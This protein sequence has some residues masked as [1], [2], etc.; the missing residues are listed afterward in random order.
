MSTVPTP[1]GTEAQVCRDIALRQQHG[2]AKYGTSVADNRLSLRAW[3][4]HAYQE[5]LDQAIYLRRAIEQ[6]DAA[7]LTG[8]S[9]CADPAGVTT[10]PP[11]PREPY[12]PP[13]PRPAF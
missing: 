5:T 11:A 6:L 4:V 8:P 3:L 10:P 1:T 13:A 7:G 9:D 2:L 12:R